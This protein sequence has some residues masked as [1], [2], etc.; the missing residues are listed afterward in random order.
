MLKEQSAWDGSYSELLHKCEQKLYYATYMQILEKEEECDLLLKQVKKHTD[1]IYRYGNF[2]AGMYS[3][4]VRD[5][6]IEQITRESK[7]ANDRKAYNRVCSRI[8][9]F[10]ESGYIAESTEMINNFKLEYRRKPAFVDEL[11]KTKINK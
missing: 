3:N 6:F 2:L 4:D 10:A 7:A 9:C 8:V 5:I 11:S 1:M